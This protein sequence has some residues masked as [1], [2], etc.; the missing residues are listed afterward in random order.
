[1]HGTGVF[2]GTSPD[3][4]L[5]KQEEQGV[6][7]VPSGQSVARGSRHN[8]K[9]NPIRLWRSLF[10]SCRNGGKAPEVRPRGGDAAGR[11]H[12]YVIAAGAFRLAP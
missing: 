11:F 2:R 8:L 9:R 6:R 10:L 4:D 3:L 7:F 5:I 12:A 1:M